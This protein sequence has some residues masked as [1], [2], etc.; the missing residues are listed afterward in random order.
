MAAKVTSR[1]AA[2]ATRMETNRC[3]N[4][5]VY[6]VRTH[7]T[8]VTTTRRGA[9]ARKASVRLCRKTAPSNH[10]NIVRATMPDKVAIN[11]ARAV[12]GRTSTPRTMAKEATSPVKASTDSV[13]QQAIGLV[14][15]MAAKAITSLVRAAI[16]PVKVVTSPAKEDITIVK[17]AST[18]AATSVREVTTTAKAATNSVVDTV[19][20][21]QTMTPTQSIA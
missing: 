1:Q 8:G 17:E 11:P 21:R 2:Q 7:Q 20:T 16:S 18:V 14:S 3:A 9:S 10:A 6:N 19:S 4:A 12:T 15:T 13:R 5:S